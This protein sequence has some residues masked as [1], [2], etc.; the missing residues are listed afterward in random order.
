MQGLY[1]SAL[2]CRQPA[3]I[4]YYLQSINVMVVLIMNCRW[5]HAITHPSAADQHSAAIRPVSWLVAAVHTVHRI[6]HVASGILLL[7]VI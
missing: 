6:V 5:R 7:A 1:T 3:V 2:L 4:P